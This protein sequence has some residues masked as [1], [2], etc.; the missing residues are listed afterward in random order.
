MLTYTL[1]VYLTA[2]SAVVSG[3][4]KCVVQGEAESIP[5]Y[6]SLAACKS[7]ERQLDKEL[8][9]AHANYKFLCIEQ[10]IRAA[11]PLAELSAQR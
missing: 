11:L 10:P 7:A 9:D 5:G 1:A 2:C 6:R 4:P 8:R 3:P